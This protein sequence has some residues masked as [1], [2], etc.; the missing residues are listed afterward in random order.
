VR[1]EKSKKNEEKFIPRSQLNLNPI[2]T[3]F[4]VPLSFVECPWQVKD[5]MLISLVTNWDIDNH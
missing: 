5:V 4:D 2:N 3:A 1:K